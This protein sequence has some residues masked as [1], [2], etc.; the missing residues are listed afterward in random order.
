MVVSTS[1]LLEYQEII[2][3]K[4]N[5]IVANNFLDFLLNQPSVIRTEVTYQWW[6]I[7]NDPD[8]NKFVDSALI[9]NADYIVTN[10]AHFDILKKN[11]FPKVK[12]I[13]L[14]DFMTILNKS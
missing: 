8:D 14:D 10:D 12:I 3:A 2:T 4:T 7:R 13:N 11:P 6:L 1:I 9:A 5:L